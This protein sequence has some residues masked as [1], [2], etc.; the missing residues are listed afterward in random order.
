MESVRSIGSGRGEA[1]ALTLVAADGTAA[2]P[3]VRALLEPGSHPRDLSDAVH[4][5]C[6]LHGRHPGVIDLAAGHAAGAAA[7]AWL[8]RAADAFAAERSYLATIVAAAGPMPST[9][10]QAESEVAEAAQRHAL[11]ML[12]RSDRTGTALGAAAALVLDWQAIRRLLDVAAS[13]F[14]IEPVAAALP[15]EAATQ[16]ALGSV[17]GAGPTRAIVFGAQQLLAQHRGLW[18]L[19][20]AR[21]AARAVA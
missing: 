7:S 21:A 4:A 16:Q 1:T 6:A 19:L 12:A 9:P 5:I 11:D 2:D 17:E 8:D 15:R 13:R 18:Q 14:G 3:H 20:E 10:G